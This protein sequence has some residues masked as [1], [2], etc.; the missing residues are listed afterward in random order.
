MQSFLGA[1]YKRSFPSA[2]RYDRDALEEDSQDIV[3]I[4]NTTDKHTSATLPPVSRDVTDSPFRSKSNQECFEILDRIYRE[5][6]SE[7]QTWDFVVMDERSLADST[8]VVVANEGSLAADEL[9][10]GEDDEVD[11]SEETEEVAFDGQYTLN[12]SGAY[13]AA[14]DRDPDQ[15]QSITAVDKDNGVEAVD[16]TEEHEYDSSA[17][18]LQTVRCSFESAANLLMLLSIGEISCA[19]ARRTAEERDGVYR[20]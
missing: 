19:D 17:G 7:I 12:R 2:R 15:D 13:V 4:R 16:G 6:G 10:D 5:T 14:D 8:V 11:V 1:T 9:S 18:G 20:D 3:V